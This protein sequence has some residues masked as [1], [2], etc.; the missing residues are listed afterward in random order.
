MLL[1]EQ[2]RSQTALG[3]RD[4]V[5][6]HRLCLNCLGRHQVADC[7]SQKVC[8]RCSSRH[9]S[10]L[11]DAFATA[12]L[13]VCGAAPA[14]A[15]LAAGPPASEGSAVLL[16]TARVLVLDRDGARHSVRAL[17]DSGSESCMVAESLAQRLR[18]P[19][20]PASV[21]IYGIGGQY[22]GV[23]RGRVSLTVASRTSGSSFGISALVFPRLTIYSGTT[24]AASRSWTHLE[25]LELADPDYFRQDPVELLLGADA[26]AHIA[27]PGLH[28][29]I[30]R[31]HV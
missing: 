27:L 2:Y 15:V 6:T 8:N 12:V 5:N 24:D 13:P 21:A 14:A 3:R 23:A 10:S 16:A 7:P 29:E 9:H 1:C 4:L 19:R 25:G 17:V 31:A 20:T 28:R 11:H 22:S 30:G 26:Y 18:L